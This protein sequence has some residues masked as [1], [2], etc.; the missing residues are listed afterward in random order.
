[1]DRRR[2]FGGDVMADPNPVF[3]PTW[4]NQGNLVRSGGNPTFL[5][6]WD[7]HG[8][9]V[10]AGTDPFLVST[11]DNHGNLIKVGDSGSGLAPNPSFTG[12]IVAN[13]GS[14]SSVRSVGPA[15]LLQATGNS[16]GTQGWGIIN[17]TL[18]N[19]LFS[20]VSDDF[21]VFPIAATLSRAGK[22]TL[23]GGLDFIG[24]ITMGGGA[25][26]PGLTNS[27]D[28]S[29]NPGMLPGNQGWNIIQRATSTSSRSFALY[30]ERN[31]SYTGNGGQTGGLEIQ[32]I[33]PATVTDE[34]PWTFL[35]AIDNSNQS[36]AANA[37]AGCFAARRRPGA[38][39]TWALV[40]ECDDYIANPTYRASAM[41][42][43]SWA[44]GGDS[45]GV[46]VTLDIIGGMGEIPGATKPDIRAG[47]R[48]GPFFGNPA[49]ARFLRGIEFY[50]DMTK[51]LDMSGI[52]TGGAGQGIIW[53]VGQQ[54]PTAANDA[55]AATAGVPVGG[56]YRNG[57][58]LMVRVA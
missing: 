50:G 10:R 57:S 38:T 30:I 49:N 28:G 22:L 31:S 12:E 19:L 29:G 51:G 4:D 14:V 35:S 58:V 47:I 34:L 43:D 2:G 42:L 36:A 46:R 33:V 5:S 11:W 52:T 37:S 13:G 27:I 26:F 9:L 20:S 8:Y 54:L 3:I 6:T 18:G 24:A 55:A 7:N 23:A 15:F 40:C 44:T 21:S 17:D 39:S 16:A 53:S 45:N 56:T 1:M 32:H 41:E 48:I 25:V